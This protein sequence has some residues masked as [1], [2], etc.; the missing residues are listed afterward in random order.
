MNSI[1][2][3]ETI[4]S[5]HSCQLETLEIAWGTCTEKQGRCMK[6][7]LYGL[8]RLSLSFKEVATSLSAVWETVSET[9]REL[10]VL[11]MGYAE[12]SQTSNCLLYTSD[13]AD[14]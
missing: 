7:H 2:P 8:Q 11:P 10:A 4:L 14:D 1:F 6:K 13:A 9:L 12:Q 5:G 3:L